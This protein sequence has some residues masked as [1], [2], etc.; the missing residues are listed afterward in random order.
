M[1]MGVIGKSQVLYKLQVHIATAGMTER[2][3]VVFCK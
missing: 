2:A 3:I 1:R